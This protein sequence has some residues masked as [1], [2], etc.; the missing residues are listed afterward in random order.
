MKYFYYQW[1]EQKRGPC[2]FSE[3]VD[4]RLPKGTYVWYEGLDSWVPIENIPLFKELYMAGRRRLS[5]DVKTIIAVSAVTLMFGI[6]IFANYN[7]EIF[8]AEFEMQNK[9]SRIAYDDPSVDFQMYVEQFY[10]ELEIYHYPLKRPNNVIIKFAELDRIPELKDLA[11]ISL[12][13]KKD[14]CIEIYIHPVAW[15]SANEAQKY[16]L[17]YHELAHDV[18]NLDHVDKTPVNEGKLMYPD[19]PE[20]CSLSDFMQARHEVFSQISD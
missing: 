4:K 11:G 14:Y 18:L 2:S 20:N 13:Y 12:G 1:D 9:L 17:I 19:I 7:A 15:F 8:K 5:N 3:M 16:W 6:V 10:N